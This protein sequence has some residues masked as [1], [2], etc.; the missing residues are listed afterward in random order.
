MKL[1]FRATSAAGLLAITAAASSG[2][3]FSQLQPCPQSCGTVGPSPSNWTT[4]HDVAR[5]SYCNQTMLFDFAIFNPLE[6]P[7]TH[8]SIR[9]CAIDRGTAATN[10]SNCSSAS[11]TSVAMQ[12]VSWGSVDTNE[13]SSV[14]SAAQSLQSQLANQIECDTPTI[15]FSYS[16]G[17][18]VGVYSGRKID[19]S[20]IINTLLTQLINQAQSQGIGKTLATQVCGSGRD[21]EHTIGLIANTQGDFGFVQEAMQTW[22]NATCLTGYDSATMSNLTISELP[23][24]KPTTLSKREQSLVERDTCS[25]IQ[26]V[27]GDSCDSL[28][29]KCG[30]SA[31]QFT[32]F[33]SDPSLCS[34]LAVGQYVCCSSGS[35]PDFTPEPSANGTCFTYTVQAGDYCALIAAN[36]QIAASSIET[37]NAQTWG[38]Q[39]CS[40]IQLGQVIC[41]SSGMPPGRV[42]LAGGTLL[43]QI[44]R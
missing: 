25:Y 33:N 18:I 13:S 40:N 35:L 12:T 34:T 41:L 38:W 39:G 24:T 3:F 32:S 42:L 31:G 26:V 30:I 4:F 14:A 20:E 28:E 23:L 5:L 10:T 37:F 2:T 36:Y 29:S 43:I 9:A 1:L 8:K 21:G 15:M 6:D 44:H 16:G 7:S 19:S 22:S 11:K 17:A 27:S